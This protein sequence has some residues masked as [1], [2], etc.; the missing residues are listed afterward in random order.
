MHA[1]SR[2]SGTAGSICPLQVTGSLLRKYSSWLEVL[3]AWLTLKPGQALYISPRPLQGIRA[4]SQHKSQWVWWVHTLAH[5]A[6]S[7]SSGLGSLQQPCSC[8]APMCCDDA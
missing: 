2:D 7:T 1:S 5:G 8:A 4:M 3:L 6:W